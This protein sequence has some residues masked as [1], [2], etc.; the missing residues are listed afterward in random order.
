[1]T[2]DPD[3]LLAVEPT[4]AVDA[5]TEAA[6]AAGLR[7]ARAGRTT[8]LTSTS[9]LLLDQADTVHYLVDG[10]VAAS[11]THRELLRTQPGYRALVTRGP[12]PAT[13]EAR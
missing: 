7:A 4:S 2:A 6:M 9:P 13:E 10:K 3:V 8:A 1:M 11:G 12:G 5:H